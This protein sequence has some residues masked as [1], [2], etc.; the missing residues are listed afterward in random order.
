ME[1]IYSDSYFKYRTL[2]NT[3]LLDIENE[4]DFW[5]E[6]RRRAEEFCKNRENK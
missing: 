4:F 5:S 2:K 6:L 3:T 1:Y